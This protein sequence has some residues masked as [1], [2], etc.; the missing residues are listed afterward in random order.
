[1]NVFNVEKSPKSYLTYSLNDDSH[2]IE[3]KTFVKSRVLLPL[4]KVLL[5][6]F[7]N[8]KLELIIRK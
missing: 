7:F 3:C 1:M 4:L 5:T 2:Y 8:Q 6:T